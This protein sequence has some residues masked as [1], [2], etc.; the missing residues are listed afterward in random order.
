MMDEENSILLIEDD[1]DSADEYIEDA[2]I[3][4]TDTHVVHEIP[5]K[6]MSGVVNLV[7]KHNA[8]AVVVD[9][10]LRQHSDANY[11]GVDV[12]NYLEN[13]IPGLP[14]VILTEYER[15]SNLKKNTK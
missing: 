7:K 14:V 9:E 3:Y 6:N 2:G 13:A 11:L 15:D 10:R 1:K 4:L 12:V 8:I 5:P